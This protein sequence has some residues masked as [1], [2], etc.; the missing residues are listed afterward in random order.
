MCTTLAVS[1]IQALSKPEILKLEYAEVLLGVNEKA[2][3]DLKYIH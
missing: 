1:F 2:F 3:R